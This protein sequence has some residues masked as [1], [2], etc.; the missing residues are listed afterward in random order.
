MVRAGRG[1]RAREGSRRVRL[2]AAAVRRPHR[3]A[4]TRGGDRQRSRGLAAARRD[5]RR[6]A[7]RP[8]PAGPS[9]APGARS[10]RRPS[11]CSSC[12][13]SAAPP[14]AGPC[15]SVPTCS[16]P[17]RSTPRRSAGQGSMTLSITATGKAAAD[18]GATHQ[19][20]AA[21][22]LG[23]RHPAV[24]RRLR[25]QEARHR[26]HDQHARHAAG[27]PVVDPELRASSPT[28]SRWPAPCSATA[29]RSITAL[30]DGKPVGIAVGPGSALQK[31]LDKAAASSGKSSEPTLSPEQVAR[32]R[33]RHHPERQGQRHRHRGR[34]ATSTAT[35]W[36][37]RCRCRRS[38][39]PR[40]SRRV[41][42][43]PRRAP[44]QA[45]PRRSST[46]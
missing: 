33:R 30:L 23:A 36:S 29:P 6:P 45:R 8:S 10:S 14:T 13:W 21:L 41:R 22:R 2:R 31:A 38:S 11:P 1:V 42:A 24:H 40:G 20:L 26:H 32:G 35:T 17:A 12:S 44:R 37:R 19:L 15:C 18:A 16:S 43:R 28:T 27:R 25:R 5:H 7:R 3:R 9:G 4:R 34:A 39:T 46:R